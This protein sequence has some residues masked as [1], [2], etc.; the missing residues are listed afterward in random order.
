MRE[1]EQQ[2]AASVAGGNGTVSPE[3]VGVGGGSPHYRYV[4]YEASGMTF[5]IK[6]DAG[7]FGELHDSGS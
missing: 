6:V 3:A 4:T 2:E 7:D 5:T 1:L